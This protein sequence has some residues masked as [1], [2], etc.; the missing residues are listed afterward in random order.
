MGAL[1]ILRDSIY[2]IVRKSLR[3]LQPD[4]GLSASD[5]V[6]LVSDG[7]MAP[8][9]ARKFWSGSL[10]GADTRRVSA[11]ASLCFVFGHGA[12]LDVE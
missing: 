7:R 1:R 3:F 11:L 8:S 6:A 2:I 5:R 12:T 9:H 4:V 10:R